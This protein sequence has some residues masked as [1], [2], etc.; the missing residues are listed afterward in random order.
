LVRGIGLYLRARLCA[1]L[2]TKKCRPRV[3]HPCPERVVKEGLA[4][5][6]ARIEQ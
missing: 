4:L 3:D 6:G 2:P 1:L 5:L